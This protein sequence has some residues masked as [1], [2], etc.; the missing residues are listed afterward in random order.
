MPMDL[1]KRLTSTLPRDL[2]LDLFDMA[3]AKALK[4][5]EL[6]RD[7]ADLDSK[8]ANEAVG[9]IRFRMQEKGFVEICEKHGGVILVDGILP[10]V[11]AKAFQPFA[12]FG[13]DR[14]GVILGLATMPVPHDLPA[15]NR[16]RLAGVMLNIDLTP[17]LFHDPDAPRV[18]DVF[19]CFLVARDRNSPGMIEEI[20]VGVID[21]LYEGY[22]FY[23]SIAEFLEDYGDGEGDTDPNGPDASPQPA[24]VRLKRTR[25]PFTPPEQK[26]G[27]AAN[28][29][30]D[31]AHDRKGKGEG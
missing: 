23:Q 6:I 25:K 1:K 7:G 18:G 21:G 30:D 10:G 11:P 31:A 17:S 5:F 24:L 26:P 29:T 9:Q 8:R 27:E 22:L 15:K 12:R 19:V 14:P 3:A 13:G 4:A 2:L 20:A 16:S 28:D